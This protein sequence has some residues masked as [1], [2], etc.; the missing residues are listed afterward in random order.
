[1]KVFLVC[2]GLGRV[3]RGFESFT[4]ECFDALAVETN[5]DI[6]LFKGGGTNNLRETV[7]WNLPRD[8]TITH[9]LATLIGRTPYFL[10][11]ATF[12]LSLLR[13]IHQHRPDVIYFS[14]GDIGTILCK[15]RRWATLDFK[16]L[17]SNG[18][19]FFLPFLRDCDYVQQLT[20]GHFQRAMDAG[21]PEDRQELVP[22][23]I[24]TPAALE[25]LSALDNEALRN[26]LGLPRQRKIVLSV[27]A[28][29]TSH[30]RLD[31]LVE[32]I[33]TLREPRPYLLM[34]GQ[35]EEESPQ[36]QRQAE[37]QLGSENFSIRT[38]SAEQMHEFY[39]VTDAFVLTSLREGFGRVFL[40]AMA[41]GLPC[42]AHDYE[43]SRFVLGE[44][45]RFGDFQVAG[46]LARLLM[47]AMTTSTDER[48][49]QRRHASAYLRFSW[50]AL[51]P[52]YRKMIEHCAKVTAG[53]LNAVR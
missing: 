23:A 4:R 43:V 51:V 15:Y 9:W 22:Y 10:E 40:E 5:I 37:Q 44:E 45:G 46:S 14:D 35:R 21:W 36:I 2:S 17:L 32:E 12:T 13:H 28:I 34:L 42:F 26:R 33:A 30:K 41:H 1:M 7:L 29:N 52:A 3:R 18:A 25:V 16:L 8:R 20:P 27:G 19:P 11:Q 31:Y 49:R 47:A 39:Q 24:N 53:G 48:D 38:V 6:H 50:E